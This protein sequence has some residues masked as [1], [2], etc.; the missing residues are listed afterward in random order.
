MLAVAIKFT[1]ILLLPFL[2]IAARPRKRRLHVLAGAALAAV[3]LAAGSLAL[4]GLALPNLSDQSTL[5][6]EFSVPNLLGLLIGAGGGAPLLLKLANVALVL[7]VA[8]LIRRRQDWLT[9][10][11]WGTLA[12][13][14]S[15]AWLVPWY[16]TWLLPLAALAGNV[17]LRRATL[18]LAAF[19]V[20]SFVPATGMV[21]TRLGIDPMAGAA[22]H[23][24]WDR[25][26]VLEQ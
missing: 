10:A 5:L 24:S 7:T 2:L 11:G 6:T 1:A 23:A 21:L 8:Y 20:L 9:G 16:I 15:L 18:V 26:L 19:L 4:F 12:L 22:G 25:Q 17:R 14:A 3:P 13:I